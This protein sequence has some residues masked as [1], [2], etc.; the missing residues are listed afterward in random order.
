MSASAQRPPR[1]KVKPL[2]DPRVPPCGTESAQAC[3]LAA[4]V[5]QRCRSDIKQQTGV[6]ASGDVDDLEV[7]DL[8]T[9]NKSVVDPE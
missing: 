6:I 9:A 1:F 5:G 4:V 2:S 3:D 7:F 8:E